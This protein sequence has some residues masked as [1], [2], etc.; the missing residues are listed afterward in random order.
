[1]LI[2]TSGTTGQPKGALIP[3][4]YLLYTMSAAPDRIDTRPDDEILTYLPL[5][6]AAERM[7]S[8]CMCLGHGMRLNFAESSETVFQNIQELS[9]TVVFGVPRIWKKFY[10]RVSTLM[11]EATWIGRLGYAWALGVGRRRAEC[12]LQGRPVPW[13]TRVQYALADLTVFRNLKQLL[14]LDR[15]RFL[16][17][18]AAPIS[19]DLLKWFLA[20]GLPISE[21]YGQTE[22]GIATMT[23]PQRPDPGTVGLPLPGVEIRLGAEDEIL[24]RSPS[25]FSG[26]LN[27]PAATDSTLVDGWVR[28]G[29]VG[30]IRPDGSIA[31]RDRLKDIIVTAG[32]KNVTPSQLE[33]VLKFSPYIADV[34]IIG[35]RRRFLSCLVM[36]DHENVEHY[37]QSNAIP[38]TDYRSLCERP[39]I[40][41]LIEAEIARANAGF[42]SVEQIKKFSLINVLL[43]A[44]D[45]EM[46]PT[47]KLK[48]SFVEAKYADV[49]AAM[50]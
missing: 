49:I 11:A 19:A 47:M 22:V 21:A 33:N 50:Y 26:Y 40:L 43:T 17:S 30:E 16:L 10:S 3:H 28:T 36:I 2:Y 9:P 45:D 27:N 35:D 1:M 37:A 41:A 6:H 24:V 4:R 31:I 46:T 25:R 7:I 32:G 42:A 15:A 34:V 29:D 8:L 44:E 48:R 12:I 38:F 39:E 20:L 14:G 13:A 23:L 18:G 5:C